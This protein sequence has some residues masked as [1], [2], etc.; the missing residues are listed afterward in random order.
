MTRTFL[1]WKSV[2]VVAVAA[3]VFASCGGDDDSGSDDS[4]SAADS[5]EQSDEDDFGEALA[6]A[7]GAGGGGTLI[8]DGQEIPIASVTCQLGDDTFDV[9]TVS[10]NDYRVL[11]SLGNPLN[12]VSA[13]VL[14]ADF[15]QWFPQGSSGDEAQR[16]GGTFS[17]ET[18]P[19]FNNS[20]DRIVQVSF[21]IEC[22]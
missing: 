6:E 13:Q 20:D 9:G 10:D 8:F 4:V 3:L 19:Y 14:D 7:S 12:D 15:L 5:T 17:S 1:T 18:T 21:T 22:P 16:D 2:A 11:V